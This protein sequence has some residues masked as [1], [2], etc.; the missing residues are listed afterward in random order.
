[1]LGIRVAALLTLAAGLTGGLFLDDDDSDQAKQ[2][3]ANAAAYEEG[4]RIEQELIRTQH[5]QAV[6]DEAIERARLKAEAAR[7]RAAAEAA[8][9]NR[10]P[11]RPYTGPIPTSCK[12]Y[13]G[14]RAIGC[15]LMLEAGHPIAEFP[16]L[17]K[18]WTKES[19]WTTTSSSPSGAYGIPQALPG[20]KMAIYGDDWQTNPATQI[21]W[22]LNYIK[23]RYSTPCGAWQHFL[24]TGWY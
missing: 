6:R 8:R 16:C 17:E 4:E 9:K 23:N 5:A 20:S 7:K 10:P 11:S 1:L 12:V 22:G 13:S 15:A 3:A 14:N 21:K 2:A 19:G 24:D 18:L